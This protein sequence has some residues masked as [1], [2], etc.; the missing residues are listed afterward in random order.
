MNKNESEGAKAVKVECVVQCNYAFVLKL[1]NSD[2]FFFALTHVQ[3]LTK[4]HEMQYKSII[5]LNAFNFYRYWTDKILCECNIVV[6]KNKSR[7]KYLTF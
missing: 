1:N 5:A 4:L 2:Y 6:S 7:C 3:M